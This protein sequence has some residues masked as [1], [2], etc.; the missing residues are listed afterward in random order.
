MRMDFR[1]ILCCICAAVILCSCMGAQAEFSPRYDALLKNT[2]MTAEIS[3]DF[4]SLESLSDA[5]LAVVNDWLSRMQIILSIRETSARSQMQAEALMDGESLFSVTSQAQPAYTLTQFSP[6]GGAYL[7]SPGAPDALALLAQAEEEMPDFSLLPDAY[8]SWASSLYPLLSQHTSAKKSK[9]TT[10]I[11]NASASAAYENYT[12]K[13]DDMNTV[14]PEILDTLLPVLESALADQPEWYQDAEELLRSLVFSG[15]CRFKRFLDK[16]GNDMGLQFT[17]NAARGD[18]VRKV[19]LFGGY[20]PDKGGYVSLALP[21]VKG[22]NNFKITLTEKLTRK[23]AQNTWTLEGTYNRT[24]DGKTQTA[25]LKAS[26]KNALKNGDETWSGKVTLESKENGVKSIWTLTPALTFTDAGLQ[27]KITVLQKVDGDQQMKANL[28]L[29]LRAAEETAAPTADTAKDL[30]GL[31]D[32]K[33]RAVVAEELTGLTRAI[34]QM[35]AAL[36]EET[37][38]L[39]TH[40]LRT[41]EW[42]TAPSVPVLNEDGVF[43]EV[44]EEESPWIVEEDKS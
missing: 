34:M 25:S 38:T 41:E 23:N 36:P 33:A 31:D 35:M 16:A 37:R 5:S 21:A 17:G 19:T 27:G 9:S 3:A 32:A 40:D 26:L 7:T 2:G 14:W 43:V 42:M 28:S 11:K 20:T 44:Q 8:L 22:K 24:Y 10:S 29:N 6:S 13:A 1:K 39:L 30:R 18:D 15:E 12:F 4:E